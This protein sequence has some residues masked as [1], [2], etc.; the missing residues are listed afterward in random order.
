[1]LDHTDNP[2]GIVTI[3]I[4]SAQSLATGKPPKIGP[5]RDR[6]FAV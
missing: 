1:M 4:G 3:P 6:R 5:G 2:G